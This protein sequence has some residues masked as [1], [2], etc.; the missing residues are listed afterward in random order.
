MVRNHTLMPKVKVR[1]R[2]THNIHLSF[3]VH[4]AQPFAQRTAELDTQCTHKRGFATTSLRHSVTHLTHEL[5]RLVA[6]VAKRVH[7]KRNKALALS[8]AVEAP[9]T[10]LLGGGSLCRGTGG[11][12]R[13]AAVLLL[14]RVRHDD[15]GDE[16]RVVDQRREVA[17]T[18]ASALNLLQSWNMI[19]K[20]EAHHP[21]LFATLSHTY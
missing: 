18:G 11:A 3:V 1:P 2:R 10:M 4:A 17:A 8:L 5:D 15:V 20:H 7:R 14:R 21:E 12:R 6:V 13:S 16:E 9:L 19:K